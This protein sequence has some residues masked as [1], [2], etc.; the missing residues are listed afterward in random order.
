MCSFAAAAAAAA[1]VGDATTQL[2]SSPRPLVPLR[3]LDK[4]L[5]PYLL[6]R[7]P[8]ATGTTHVF[9]AVCDHFEPLHDTDKAGAVRRIEHWAGQ[10]PRSIAPFR[11]ADGHPPKHTF[12]YPVEQY[13]PDLLAPLAALCQATGSE[14]EIHL[15]HEGDTPDGF[16]E[17]LEQGKEDLRRHGL[18][19]RD[20]TGRT[21]FGFIHGNWALNN[22]HPEGKGCGVD[23]EIGILRESGC[24]ADFTMPSA[25]S[26][27]QSRVVNRIAY[28]ADLPRH[29]AYSASTEST[30]T[31]GSSFRE[32]PG[33]L[34][35][36]PGPLALNWKKRK[37]GLLPRLE[38]GDLTGA[39]PPTALRL[40]LA[41]R[42]R[43]SV[44]G[45]SDWVFVKW[46]THGGIEPNSDTL[47][48]EPMRQFHERITR[49]EG[50]QVHYVTAREMANLVHAAEDGITG[51]PAPYRDYLFRITPGDR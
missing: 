29:E 30:R 45:N 26:P 7:L 46:H 16:R 18:L 10:F 8:P 2:P 44:S 39:N 17:A 42:Q 51:D 49:L 43:I 24:Y 21:R 6:R 32:D 25:P 33:R 14:V 27:T 11:D 38:N 13:D 3:A 19:C 36:I 1:A 35:A 47:L 15:H 23:Q 50:L 22:T 40:R 48:G 5:L 28:L 9:I 37:W 12:F 34:L 4:W 20:T 31:T 41:S